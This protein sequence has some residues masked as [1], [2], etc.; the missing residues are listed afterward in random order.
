MIPLR[1]S[2]MLSSGVVTLGDGLPLD[3]ILDWAWCRRELGDALYQPGT[4][5][6]RPALPLREITFGGWHGAWCWSASWAVIPDDA[7]RGTQWWHKK[8]LPEV[9]GVTVEMPGRTLNHTGGRYKEQRQALP[10]V[11]TPALTWYCVG[12]QAG[13]AELLGYVLGVGKKVDQGN[14][15]VREWRVEPWEADWSLIRDGQPMRALPLPLARRLGVTGGVRQVCGY[16]PPYY[17][18]THQEECLT[19]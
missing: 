14:G 7:P 19:P 3:A 5:M 2:A 1:V 15:W 17:V 8:T 4:P 10:T 13:V 11:W 9:P 16:R 12:D 18:R 6:L